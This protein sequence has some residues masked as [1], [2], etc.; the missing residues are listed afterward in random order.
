MDITEIKKLPKAKQILL[1]QDIW[2]LLEK[3]ALELTDEIKAE[4]D[5]RLKH[6]NSGEGKYYT[7][8]ESRKRN[9][10]RRNGI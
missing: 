4:L 3:D 6:H 1:V 2:D 5:N 10:E 8:E 7:L 9:A